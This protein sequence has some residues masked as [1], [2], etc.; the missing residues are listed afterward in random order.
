M[1]QIVTGHEPPYTQIRTEKFWD[2]FTNGELVDYDV[3]MQ[4]QPA[5]NANAKKAAAKLRVFQRQ[6]DIRGFVKPAAQKTIDL[7]NSLVPAVLTSARATEIL[8]T[9]ITA[10]E[11]YIVPGEMQ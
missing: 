1:P 5:D 8:T 4:H 9:P 6:K 10:N 2:R 11:A 7:V 3:A